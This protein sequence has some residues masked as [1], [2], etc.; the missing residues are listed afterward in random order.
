MT[1]KR[2]FGQNSMKK[3]AIK[4]FRTKFIQLVPTMH[5]KALN[6]IISGEIPEN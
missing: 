2:V 5:K 3:Y 1:T 4:M 6:V